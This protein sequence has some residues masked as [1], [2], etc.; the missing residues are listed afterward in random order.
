MHQSKKR[1][2][3][4]ILGP[5][6]SGKTSLAVALA[7]RLE[8]EIVSADS[9]Q[10]YKGLDLGS[11]KDLEEY[12]SDGKKIPYHLIDV[13]EPQENYDVFR[14][15]DDFFK[16]YQGLVKAKKWVILCGGSGLYLQAAL[17]AEKMLTV[18]I[19]E[20]LRAELASLS[21][22]ELV[23]HL[24]QLKAEQH[25][26][27]DLE[28][29]ERTLRAIEIAVAQNQN[30]KQEPSPVKEYKLFGL[31][32][33]RSK[34]RERIKQRLE[35]RFK[36]GMVEEVEGLIQAGL[37]VEKLHYF[38]LEYRYIASY[39]SGDLSYTQ[40]FEGL[41]QAIRK[42]AKKQE[43]WYRRMEK[44]GE[45]IHWLELEMQEEEM[46]NKILKIVKQDGL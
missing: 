4:T 39:L 5:T 35:A 45:T 19:N 46:I 12:E 14:F 11:G 31:K 43:T 29:R 18:P 36:Q 22:G 37:S 10:V 20:P 1:P 7:A 38:G 23:N 24:T 16:I 34:L 27:T 15:Q 21:Q 26:T 28:D 44:R 25:N 41:L 8:G 33:E 6:A 9:R 17:A 13:V 32:V 42:F 3:I 40:M 30:P 2:L